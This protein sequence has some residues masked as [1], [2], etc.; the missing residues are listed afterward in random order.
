MLTRS[1]GTLVEMR[2]G[3]PD[4]LGVAT[5]FAQKR[6][7]RERMNVRTAT[8]LTHCLAGPLSPDWQDRLA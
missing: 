6:A 8:W 1:L 2:R 3:L 5:G 7:Q 4:T